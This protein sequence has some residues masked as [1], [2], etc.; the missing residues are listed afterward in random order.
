MKKP[1]VYVH[2]NHEIEIWLNGKQIKMTD[3]QFAEISRQLDEILPY[4]RDVYAFFE[5]SNTYE[6]PEE[7]II[8]NISTRYSVACSKNDNMTIPE[9]M[10][11]LSAIVQDYD[12][13]LTKVLYKSDTL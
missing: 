4:K 5:T 10:E 2:D 12:A 6:T 11:L 9:K 3:E 13:N 1:I 8:D 7:T